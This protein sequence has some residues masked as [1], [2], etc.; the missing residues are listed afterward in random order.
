MNK[1]YY[2]EYCN[3]ILG[4]KTNAKDFKWVYG[5]VAPLAKKE[6]YEQCRVKFDIQVKPEAKLGTAFNVDRKFQA[7]TWDEDSQTLYYRRKLFL[8][9]H[10]GFNIKIV[11]NVV[12]AEIGEHYYKHIK[13]R[14]MNLHGMYYLL[15]DIANI[16]LLKNGLLTL[17]AAAVY[18]D[19]K[20]KGR[21]LFGAP[22][23]GKTLTAMKVCENQNYSLL[24]EDILITD[25]IQIFS[26]PWTMSFRKKSSIIDDA[27]ACGRKSIE[28]NI[29][30]CEHCELTDVSV[31]SI[32]KKKIESEKKILFNQIS[33]LNGYLF[34]YYS[35]PIVKVLAFMKQEYQK[36]WETM[37]KLM[38][39]KIIANCACRGIQA[40]KPELFSE[41]ILQEENN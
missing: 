7:Y 11:E 30:H 12:C 31:L 23:T 29:K 25:G 21:V 4:V 16:M 3:G 41:I 2:Y 40:E 8:N 32:G 36:E 38:L 28:G 9:F 24:G 5:S 13:N 39:E 10:I 27:G 20:K 26:C 22:T 37:A 19:N 15:S 1:E 14:T 17:Y 6:K 35:S 34:N 18:N 33:I